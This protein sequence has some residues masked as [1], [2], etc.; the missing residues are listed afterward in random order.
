MNKTIK[1][2]LLLARPV[3]VFITGLSIFLGALISAPHHYWQVAVLWACLAGAFIA[4]GANAINDYFDVEIDRINKPSRPIP[5]GKI[6]PQTALYLAIIEFSIGLVLNLF[7][8]W[9]MFA[10][11]FLTTVLLILYSAHFKRTALWGNLLVSAITFLAFFYGGM[12]VGR[13]QEAIIPG[14]FS[15]FFHWGREI[16]KDL[17]DVEGDIAN[18][19]QTFPI[20][21]GH[22]ATIQLVHGIFSLLIIVTYLPYRVHWYSVTYF[23]TVL[24]GI[25]PVLIFVLWR[26]RKNPPPR[27]LGFL[28]NLLKA[29]M[30]V[31]LLALYL[32]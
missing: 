8:P 13:P 26:L 3:N 2:I 14:I 32:R 21:Y 9:E 16:I 22:R 12:A 5:S 27:E 25:Y 24:I 1:G 17:Q 11:A 29:D 20:K 18:N 28:S 19:A 10:V 6:S 23:V 31:G 15:F 7:L 4:A 30:L